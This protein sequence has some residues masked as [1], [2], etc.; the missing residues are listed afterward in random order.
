MEVQYRTKSGLIF[1]IP[2]TTQKD[3]W[4][5]ISEIE[6]VFDADDSCGICQSNNIRHRVRVHDD[7]KYYE[8]KCLD[9]GAQLAFGQ[10]K[11]GDTLFAKRSNDN[12]PLPN[13]GWYKWQGKNKP[14]AT[15]S[16]DEV[17]F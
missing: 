12:G 9:C 5:S 6:D 1:K 13:R 16:D 4:E 3:L 2:F 7:N 15:Q 8:L 10:H 11:K 14:Q 17:P